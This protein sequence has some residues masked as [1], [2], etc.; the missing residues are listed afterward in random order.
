MALSAPYPAG[1]NGGPYLYVATSWSSISQIATTGGGKTSFISSIVA[2]YALAV[3]GNVLYVTNNAQNSNG[4]CS[5]SKY[6]ADTGGV[7]NAN[8]I[9]IKTSAL[10]GLALQGNILYVSVYSGSTP[11]VY[12]YAAD[13][14]L[15][16]SPTGQQP[17]KEPFVSVNEPWGIAIGSPPLNA[18]LNGQHP[19]L[20]VASHYNSVINEF[21]A[22]TG[23]KLSY[24]ITV[25]APANITVEPAAAL[26]P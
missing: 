11:G 6:T 20:Y 5:I 22:T 3:N 17:I 15:P 7:I 24:S 12:T 10:Y 16:I 25:L 4:E 21:D 13:T 18:P 1:P 19:T 9:L 23:A 2:P 26:G 8:F 14:G